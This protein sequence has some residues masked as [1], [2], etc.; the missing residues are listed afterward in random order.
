MKKIVERI[1]YEPAVVFGVLVVGTN[2]AGLAFHLD[3][4]V[5]VSGVVAAIGAVFTRNNVTPTRKLEPK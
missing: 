1:Y 3:W 5:A 2:A 4:L